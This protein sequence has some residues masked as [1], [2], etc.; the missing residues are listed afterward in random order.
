M[1]NLQTTIDEPTPDHDASAGVPDARQ[2][3]ATSPRTS[4]FDPQ[5]HYLE[6]AAI[7]LRTN[8]RLVSN[9]E[10]GAWKRCPR[11]WWLAWYRSLHTQVER[12]TGVM[13][14]GDR[15]HRAL[16]EWLD[17]ARDGERPDLVVILDRLITEDIAELKKI[18]SEGR[19]PSL[20]AS[21]TEDADLQK[22][23]LEGYQQWVLDTGADDN[24]E[25]LAV[26]Q[27]R[28]AR[29]G[30]FESRGLP[31]YLIAKFD[32]WLRREHDGV[33]LFMD[34]KS[35][36]DFVKKVSMISMDPQLL[37]YH[38]IEILN[39]V[40]GDQRAGGAIYNMM[41]RVKRTSRAKPPFYQ[42][43]PVEFS[44]AQLEAF[45]Q[46]LAGTLTS[47]FQAERLLDEGRNPQSIVPPNPTPDC[48]WECPFVAIC[49]RFE[50]GSRVEAMIESQFVSIDPLSYYK[51]KTADTM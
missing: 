44:R 26:E 7:G 38:L 43:M 48:I 22:I 25:V 10:I 11:K 34:H 49:P 24:L 33:R 31:V 32:V 42:R 45:N 30:S 23:M 13:A 14:I 12:S 8:A 15:I 2:A 1:I 21:L 3:P 36:G 6:R 28:E 50:D 39:G 5:A 37:L 16:A 46:H 51:P 20:L 29:Y 19:W 27:Y 40:P 17:P 4:V 9:S 18:T 47:L 35:V 41:R